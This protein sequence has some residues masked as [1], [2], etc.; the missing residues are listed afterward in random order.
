M[1]FGPP[2]WR[3]QYLLINILGSSFIAITHSSLSKEKT[4]STLPVN[5]ATSVVNSAGILFIKQ[6]LLDFWLFLWNGSRETLP[7]PSCPWGMEPGWSR[8]G[9]GRGQSHGRGGPTT[10]AFWQFLKEGGSSWSL[11]Q[12]PPCQ[13]RNICWRNHKGETILAALLFIP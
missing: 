12:G 1:D 10:A 3:F 13:G 9:R 11:A 7:C 4:L 5:W 8:Q 6:R 2:L